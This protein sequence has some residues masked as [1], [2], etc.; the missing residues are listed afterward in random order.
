L[1][2]SKVIHL[3]IH[4]FS[5]YRTGLRLN[6]GIRI[7]KF[8]GTAI[9]EQDHIF[10]SKDCYAL[11]GSHLDDLNCVFVM[12]GY[13]LAPNGKFLHACVGIFTGD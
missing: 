4:C 10:H 3:S 1:A 5:F 8:F 12:V 7:Q 9:F 6:L 13:D 11:L 2:G